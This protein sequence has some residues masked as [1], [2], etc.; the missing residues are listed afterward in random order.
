MARRGASW[1][2][3]LVFPIFPVS[4]LCRGFCRFANQVSFQE[5]NNSGNKKP[6]NI[7]KLSGLSQEWIGSNFE[8]RYV[9]SVVLESGNASRAFLQTPTPI[10][11]KLPGPMD[12]RFL[13]S[14]GRGLAPVQGEHNS[15]QY[16]HWIKIDGVKFVYVF[17]FS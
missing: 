9:S 13:S 5:G 17:P 3:K 7:N 6:I 4:G 11:D 16:P 15:S 8:D 1:V 10:L 12:A 2:P 14:V